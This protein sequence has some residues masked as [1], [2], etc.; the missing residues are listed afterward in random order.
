[1]SDTKKVAMSE[2]FELESWHDVIDDGADCGI[3]GDEM[4]V[5]QRAIYV[6]AGFTEPPWDK[7]SVIAHLGCAIN[8]NEV[9]L[10]A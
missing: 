10:D 9:D 8:G 4:E 7:A 5:G 1:M 2:S 3:C 6:P